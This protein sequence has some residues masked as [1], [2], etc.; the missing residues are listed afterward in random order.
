M[1]VAQEFLKAWGPAGLISVV[2]WI[3]LQKSEKREEK[4]DT[5]IQMLENLLTESYDERISAADRIAEA[6]HGNA[7]ALIALVNEIRSK[8]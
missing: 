8:K 5:R 2:L 3:M 1:E 6:I 4:K 7:T